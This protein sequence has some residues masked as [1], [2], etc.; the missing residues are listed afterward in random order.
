MT[1]LGHTSTLLIDLSVWSVI[2]VILC[3]ICM[4]VSGLVGALTG[5]RMV[6]DLN[7]GRPPEAKFTAIGW[8]ANFELYDVLSEYRRLYPRA[9]LL[10]R[11]IWSYVCGFL[12]VT[13]A[14]GILTGILGAAWLAFG[15]AFLGWLTWRISSPRAS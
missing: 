15:G 1:T 4:A 9:A 5:L 12:A 10:R 13:V 8:R 14:A 6:D 11:A 7:K 2:V 3:A